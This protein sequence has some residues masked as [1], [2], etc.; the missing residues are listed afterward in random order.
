MTPDPSPTG[1]PLDER[2][3]MDR[4]VSPNGFDGYGPVPDKVNEAARR[5]AGL[6]VKHS[7]GKV[8]TAPEDADL[9]TASAVIAEWLRE[10]TEARDALTER[11]TLAEGALQSLIDRHPDSKPGEHPAVDIARNYFSPPTTEGTTNE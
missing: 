1:I 10:V 3:I 7:L 5:I 9:F 8:M 6:N 2:P 4:L 11:L